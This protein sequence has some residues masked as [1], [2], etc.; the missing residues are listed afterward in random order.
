MRHIVTD[1]VLFMETASHYERK[2]AATE[3][4]LTYY[5]HA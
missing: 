3:L 5:V 2:K 1:P 4:V